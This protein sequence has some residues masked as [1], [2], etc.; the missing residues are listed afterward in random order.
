M[1]RY[2]PQDHASDD[3]VETSGPAADLTD[4]LFAWMRRAQVRTC[5]PPMPPLARDAAQWWLATMCDPEPL[6]IDG[7]DSRNRRLVSEYTAACRSS[8]RGFLGLTGP[9]RRSVVAVCTD[10]SL[11][12]RYRWDDFATFYRIAEQADVYARDPDKYIRDALS[13]AKR[14]TE[15]MTS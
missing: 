6:Q 13:M 14:Q 8:L 10:D 2:S 4:Y 7:D 9:Q 1:S 5:P 3:T 15:R 11:P 12:V